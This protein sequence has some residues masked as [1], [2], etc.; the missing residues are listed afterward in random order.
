MEIDIARHWGITPQKIC[1]FRTRDPHN[2]DEMFVI[3]NR[4]FLKSER[5]F[6][7]NMLRMMSVLKSQGIPIL[8]P[9]QDKVVKDAGKSWL[10]YDFIKDKGIDFI[11]DKGIAQQIG[12][13]ISFIERT[14][15]KKLR[16]ELI[17]EDIADSILKI[18]KQFSGKDACDERFRIV[19]K[20]YKHLQDNLFPYAPYLNRKFTHG[21]LH[22]DNL[23]IE[24]DRLRGII[25]WEIAG[26]REELYD[27]AYILGCIGI[28][29]PP[30]LAGEFARNLITSFAKNSRP[31]MLAKELLLEMVMATR[32]KWLYKWTL[33]PSDQDII[34]METKLISMLYDKQEGLRNLWSKW[35][36][37][38]QEQD[39]TDWIMQNAH[40]VK[41]IDEAKQR[42]KDKS[43]L[44]TDA[45]IDDIERYSTDLRLIAIDFGMKKDI[46]QMTGILNQFERLSHKY[47]NNRHFLVEKMLLYGN[48]C[49]AFSQTGMFGA[50]DII[51]AR[52][53][54]E[55]EKHQDTQDLLIGYSAVLRN[56]S[57]AFAEAKETK[58]SFQMISRLMEISGSSRDAQIKGEL[59]RALSNGITTILA[60]DKESHEE[61]RQRFLRILKRLYQENPDSKKVLG[62]YRIAESNLRKAGIKKNQNEEETI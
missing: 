6:D 12:K 28:S 52:A 62:A 60:N 51:M 45:G 16:L 56:A 34:D 13:S 48:I 32:L 26:M 30:E 29:D 14:D 1:R 54:E 27:L 42:M 4:L 33:N 57:I 11:K 46:I 58:R 55:L 5:N 25:D 31:S 36:E 22:L 37:E 40:M 47:P 8:L 43:F 3:D 35:I 7:G 2:T 20:A 38:A 23:L 59:A 44:D 9:K 19:P 50:V 17:D 39:K 18:K 53:E 61:E 10:M 49:L 15:Q 41:D 24:E 21:D